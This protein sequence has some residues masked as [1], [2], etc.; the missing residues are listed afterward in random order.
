MC[1]L[2]SSVG[3]MPTLP[4]A[5][6]LNR[7]VLAG[8]SMTPSRCSR[9][10]SSSPSCRLNRSCGSPPG[11]LTASRVARMTAGTVS[12]R[13]RAGS[14]SMS[15]HSSASMWKSQRGQ[16]RQGAAPAPGSRWRSAGCS[17]WEAVALPVPVAGADRRDLR[18]RVEQGPHAGLVRRRGSTNMWSTPAGEVRRTNLSTFSGVQHGAHRADPQRLPRRDAQWCLGHGLNLQEPGADERDRRAVGAPWSTATCRCR[19]PRR[20]S[21]PRSPP[22]P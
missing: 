17:G 2:K 5:W 12:S 6:L 3:R 13:A 4:C 22:G 21:T 7:L 19:R 11:V 16:S 18:Q 15:R 10:R 8:R 9:A 14:W 1:R 20:T